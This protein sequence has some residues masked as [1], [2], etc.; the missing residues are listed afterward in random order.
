[1]QVYVLK[2]LQRPAYKSQQRVFKI[3]SLIHSAKYM[4]QNHH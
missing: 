1:M 2:N 3:L 4:Q